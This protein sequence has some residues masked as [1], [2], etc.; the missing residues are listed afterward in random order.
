MAR[1]LTS[2]ACLAMIGLSGCTTARVYHH[3]TLPLDV[4]FRDTPVTDLN[5]GGNTKQFRY[6]V[7]FNWD[8]NGIGDIAK[9]AGFK[10]VYY[11]DRTVLSV[12]G[13]W[14][15]VFVTVYGE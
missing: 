5:A 4:N 8:S 13:I 9:K 10:K 3:V 6:Y 2:C 12:L 7:D 15:Q 1:L 14:K 11:A